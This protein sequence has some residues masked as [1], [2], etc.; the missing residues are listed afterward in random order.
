MS[1][2]STVRAH[3]RLFNPPAPFVRAAAAIAVTVFSAGALAQ[4]TLETPVQKFSYTVGMQIGA[5]LKNAG[6]EDL[7][8]DALK[9]A[10]GDAL[11]GNE[12]RVSKEDAAAAA[13]TFQ[14]AIEKKKSQAGEANL[15]AGKAFLEQNK[16]AEGVTVTDSGVQ[17]K[18]IEAGNGEQPGPNDEV[19]VHYRGQLL[20]GQEFDSSF[21]RGE[22]TTFTVGQVIPG[23][24]EA[25]QLMKA[26]GEWEVWIPSE[27]AYGPRGAGGSI[28][29]HEV[30]HFTI[31]LQ[32]VNK[33]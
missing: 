10:I 21:S 30:L 20:S 9:L 8:L 1:E 17:Y 2:F 23:W 31:N 32:S 28:G 19:V 11:A 4:D 22:P 7:D 6:L 5:Q 27:L 18:V 12:P 14:A 15:A 24:Q 29:P 3:P 26:G 16:S 13:Q 25:L 33:K